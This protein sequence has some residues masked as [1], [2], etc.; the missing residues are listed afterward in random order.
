MSRKTKWISGLIVLL[1]LFSCGSK[2]KQKE[3]DGKLFEKLKEEKGYLNGLELKRLD[4]NFSLKALDKY[5]FSGYDE[6]DTLAYFVRSGAYVW[7]ASCYLGEDDDPNPFFCLKEEKEDRFK[8][9]RHG[10]IPALN[11]A[12]SYDLEQL[13]VLAGNY[14]LVSQKS[15]GNG[16]CFDSPLVFTSDGTPVRKSDDRFHFVSRNCGEGID[17]G[18][19]FKRDFTYKMEKSVLLVQVKE[20]QTDEETEQEISRRSFELRFKVRNRTIYFQDTIFK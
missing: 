11:G 10:I 13:L 5:D 14:V 17:Q 7:I 2:R 12:C 1:I 15:N 6:Q 8:M 3:N 19:C 4:T 16:S 18:L 9:M 20:K